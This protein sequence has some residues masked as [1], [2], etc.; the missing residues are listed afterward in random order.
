MSSL[1]RLGPKCLIRYLL[2]VACGLL[3]ANGL[4]AT[5]PNAG[6]AEEKPKQANIAEVY[7]SRCESCHPNLGPVI[8]YKWAGSDASELASYTQRTMPPGDDEPL[9]GETATRLADYMLE[10][11]RASLGE[12]SK[13]E[14]AVAREARARLRATAERLTPVTDAVLK[15]PPKG[16][17]LAWRGNVGAG[18]FSGLTQINPSNV[19][20]LRLVWSKTLGPGTNGIGPLAHDGVIFVYGGGSISAIDAVSGDTIWTHLAT[21]KKRDIT[22]PRGV[23]LYGSALYASTVDNHVMALDAKTGELRW[24]RQVTNSGKFTF[25]APPLA[26]NGKVFQASAMCTAR[27]ARC[28]MTALDAATGEEIWRT[29]TIPG[30]GE[31]GSESWGDTPAGQRSGAGSWSGASYDYDKGQIIFGTGNTYG[32]ANLLRNG[33]ANIPAALY[34]NTTIK[35]DAQTGKVVWSYQHFPG[36]VW[37]EDW[38]FERTIVKD[39]R[40]SGRL[41][42]INVGKLGILDAL[43]LETGRYLWSIDLGFQD[44][45]T[46][47]DSQTGAK[48]IDLSKVPVPGQPATVCPFAGGVRNWPA[49][50]YDPDRSLLFV[51]I[52]DACMQFSIERSS[53]AQ[54]QQSVWRVMPRPGS[55]GQYGGLM[56]LDLR[57]GKPLWTVRHRADPAS[58]VLATKSGVIFAG[59][60]DR[61]FRARDARTGKTLWQVRL[62]DTPNSFPITFMAGGRQYIAVVTGGGTYVDQFVSHLIPEV[63]PSRGK[64]ALWLFALDS[65]VENP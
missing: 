45:V 25:T 26:A 24:D 61:W 8:Q 48:A 53:K 62:A 16:D 15:A 65:G 57:T 64:M 49:T 4:A 10:L 34:T 29:Y 21:T 54:A 46:H 28:F 42:V 39:P 52:L 63:E 13:H 17:W 56:A 50:S 9:D 36:D 19:K 14:D 55:D 41:A 11:G 22:Q 33:P 31:P 2:C 40:G 1:K 6:A 35:L 44:L 59:A 20:G 38:T 58:A 12:S 43:D 23:S 18:G 51:P 7:A 5:V 32:V 37:D 47:I 27:G 30:D 3:A 60:R